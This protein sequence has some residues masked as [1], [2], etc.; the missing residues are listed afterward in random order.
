M[1]APGPIER[2]LVS[3]HVNGSADEGRIVAA[4]VEAA[5]REAGLS[6]EQSA[7]LARAA[8][9]VARA[10]DLRGFDDPEEAAVD[11]SLV[12]VG[13]QVILR[14]DDQGLPFN[15]AAED[16]VDGAVIS[17]SLEKGWID[18][19]RHESLGRAGN[20]TVL[21]RHIDAGVDLRESAS[22]EDH[23]A[24]TAAPPVAAHVEIETRMGTP[25]DADAICQLAWRT[26]GYT[27]QHDEYYLPGRLASM[28]AS[29]RQVSFV[30]LTTDA[31]VVGHTAL[32]V[33]SS[34]AVLV[35]AGRGM[36]DPRFRGHHLM[37]TAAKIQGEWM[38]A[39][40]ILAME[41]AAVTAHTRT[42]S[43]E[44]VANIQLAFLP[45]IEFR[46][47]PGTG[48]LTRQTV[49]G[50]I[51]PVAEIPVQQ[52]YA[53]GRDA[54]MLEEI[55]QATRF[56]RRLLDGS[57]AAPAARDATRLHVL[58]RADMGH[59]VLEVREIGH[60][61]ATVI[62][63]RMRAVRD[64]GIDVTYCDLPLDAPSVAWASEELADQGFVFAGPLALK[65]DGIDVVRYQCLGDTQ[66]DPSEIHLK[67][68]LAERLLD[69][70][71][72]QLA[73]QNRAR[74]RT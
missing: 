31:M 70:V 69:Y 22:I 6:S 43:D 65:Y 56:P 41:A 32:L 5:A 58:A 55:Y 71:L 26:Y 60:D 52:V 68:R 34:D 29:G 14:I 2:T 53:P 61:F 62:S 30:N 57:S 37:R 10:I 15:Y 23:H 16:E 39:H 72:S 50:S 40:G 49:V 63:E 18:E 4:V 9:A 54:G 35:E 13:H 46:K 21:A 59:A 8:R 20:R 45:P 19:F 51:Y 11:L 48:V 3:L 24:A 74:R 66:V 42:Q 27:Y 17:E 12:V 25:D 38:S 36:V 67:S 44:L 28:I 7:H 47:M 1:K 64:G 73:D 33:E